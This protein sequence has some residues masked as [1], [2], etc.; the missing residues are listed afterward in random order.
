MTAPFQLHRPTS[1]QEATALLAELGDGATLYCGGT[2]LLQVMKMGLASFDHLIDVKPIEALRG[3][4]VDADGTLRI[5]AAVTHREI[6]RSPVIAERLPSLAELEQHVA[7]VRVRN[8]G[9]LGGN[10]CFAEPHSDPATLL[11]A[12]GAVLHLA[13]PGGS[14]DVAL[15]G[16]ILG[17]LTTVREPDEI[18]VS[19]SVPQVP[20]NT[21]MAYRK[22]AFHE[23]PV[24]SVAA[25]VTVA[26]GRIESASVVVGSVGERPVAIAGVE[27]ILAG[28]ALNETNAAV[29]EAAQAAAAACEAGADISGSEEYQRHLVMVLSRRALAAAIAQASRSVS[30]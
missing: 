2:E 25:R 3:I 15:E 14:R 10:L 8:A 4:S 7:N 16:F 19:V 13:G 28:A 20:S 27:P 12:A 29:Q 21:F 30:Q 6:E 18:L 5:G 26:D 17:P 1:I 24:A 11:I 23:R 22:I 9:S